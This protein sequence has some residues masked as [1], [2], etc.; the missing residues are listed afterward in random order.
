MRL[1][2]LIRRKFDGDSALGRENAKYG[3]DIWRHRKK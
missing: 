3:E 1:Y 2:P